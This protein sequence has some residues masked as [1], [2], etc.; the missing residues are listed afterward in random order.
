MQITV[1]LMGMLKDRAPTDGTL[2][3]SVG[4]TIL[5]VLTA[6]EIEPE[7]VQVFTVNGSLVRD[8]SH[9]LHEGDELTVLP[10][11]GGG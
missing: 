9:E 1:K 8:K 11:V 5:D 2:E 10:P 3:L 4:A 7:T 6:L